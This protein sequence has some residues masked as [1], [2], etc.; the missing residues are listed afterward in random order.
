MLSWWQDLSK[1]LL[2]FPCF[3][4]DVSMLFSLNREA[5]SGHT[6]D[7]APY[8]GFAWTHRYALS[9][10]SAFQ[11][12]THDLYLLT[13]GH[14]SGVCV[15]HFVVK[16]DS[17]LL[18]TYSQHEDLSKLLFLRSKGFYKWPGQTMKKFGEGLMA[19]SFPVPR[20]ATWTENLTTWQ[21]VFALHRNI[22][23]EFTGWEIQ[24]MHLFVYLE[25][26]LP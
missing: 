26:W 17:F 10:N 14:N 4:T 21:R 7:T 24:V 5:L 22:F 12:R 19:E 13:A 9:K 1:S 18:K 23:D 20:P 16:L 6:M 15:Y 3:L 25:T 2:C 8:I 11:L